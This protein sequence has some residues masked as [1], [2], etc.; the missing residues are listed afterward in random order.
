MAETLPGFE[1]TNWIGIFAP[2]GTPTEIVT[3]LNAEIMRIMR[4]PE[5]QSR[6]VNEGAKSRPNTPGEFAA[7]A[8]AET[9]KWGKVIRDAGVHVD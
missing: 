6:L 9:I 8:K 1:V 5:V 3:R 2:A 7:F 4:L